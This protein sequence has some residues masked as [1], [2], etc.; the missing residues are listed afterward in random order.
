MSFPKGIRRAARIVVLDSQD[1]VLLF[2]FSDPGSGDEFWA[3]PGG[4]VAQGETYLEAAT[5]ELQEETGL[6]IEGQVEGPVWTRRSFFRWNG[7]EIDQAEE[8]YLAR[9]GQTELGD[10]VTGDH[11]LE[12]IVEHAWW[13]VD[14]VASIELPVFP[15][16]L[17]THLRAL[18]EDG[19]AGTPLAIES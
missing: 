9:T 17:E 14:E 19:W 3:T 15:P 16:G 7:L 10:D 6:P 1:R 18:L 2:R 11:D 13:T 5:R 8:Y 4:G 12:N